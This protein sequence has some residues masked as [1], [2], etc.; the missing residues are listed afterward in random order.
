MD[1]D[2]FWKE[3]LMNAN[4]EFLF[5]ASINGGQGLSSERQGVVKGHAYSVLKAVEEKGE[6]LLLLRHAQFIS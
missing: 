3:G 1:R 2:L 6:H 5:A 4:K